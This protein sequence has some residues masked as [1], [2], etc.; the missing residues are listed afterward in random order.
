[1]VSNGMPGLNLFGLYREAKV[2]RDFLLKA[3]KEKRVSYE[4]E[5]YSDD[6]F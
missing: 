2:A 6:P 1:M 3:A 4:A 5:E